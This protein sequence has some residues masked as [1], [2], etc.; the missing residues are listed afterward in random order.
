[1][2]N[3]SAQERAEKN[4]RSRIYYN[5]N[6]KGMTPEL[7]LEKAKNPR[8]KRI[9]NP[10]IHIA[11]IPLLKSD[12][13]NPENNLP[14]PENQKSEI[15]DPTPEQ[16][17][18]E[19]DRLKRLGLMT[20][21]TC[22]SAGNNIQKQPE[23]NPENTPPDNSIELGVCIL[24]AV[25]AAGI[26]VKNTA[27]VWNYSVEGWI[28][29]AI[30]EIGICGFSIYRP[31][32]IVLNVLTKLVAGALIGLSLMTQY[33]GVARHESNAVSMVESSEETI[34]NL[35][36]ALTLAVKTHKS[37]AKWQKAETLKEVNKAT[38]K[39]NQALEAKQKPAAALVADVSVVKLSSVVELCYRAAFMLVLIGFSAR[40]RQLLQKAL[41]RRGINLI[42]NV[43]AVN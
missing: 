33:T 39:L 15:S 19:I 13:Q 11:E 25:C 27:E 6:V 41:R 3:L 24:V 2:S 5:Q 36:S 1:M 28:K 42:T 38:E 18:T 20:E 12:D 37:A 34:N 10:A 23:K 14:E 9:R 16:I 35:R 32:D 7:A 29:A 17:Q 4:F 8:P 21:I 40:T 26:L 43:S 31:H 30:L 22:S